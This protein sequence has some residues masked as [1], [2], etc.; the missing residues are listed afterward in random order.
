MILL[1]NPGAGHDGHD[2]LAGN[3]GPGPFRAELR[4]LRRGGARLGLMLFPLTLSGRL[5]SWQ[6]SPPTGSQSSE[7]FFSWQY[8]YPQNPSLKGAGT[9]DTPI[10]RQSSY[11]NNTPSRTRSRVAES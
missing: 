10:F 3:L 8:P 7:T 4:N 6:Q 5:Q 11:V 2:P 1:I 9:S